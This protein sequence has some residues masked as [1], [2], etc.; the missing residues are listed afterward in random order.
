MNCFRPSLVEAV[1][2]E[3][4]SGVKDELSV[5]CM[6]RKPSG[7]ML[8]AEF[9]VMS[10]NKGTNQSSVICQSRVACGYIQALREAPFMKS[11]LEV[12]LSIGSVTLPSI[13][14]S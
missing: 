1:T 7:G 11:S 4:V 9:C 6:N 3:D 12:D 8:T 10:A 13:I 2:E 5:E 14:R